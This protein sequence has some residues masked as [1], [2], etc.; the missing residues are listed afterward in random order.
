M[1]KIR[2]QQLVIGRKDLVVQQRILTIIYNIATAPGFIIKSMANYTRCIDICC[3][4]FMRSLW[5]YPIVVYGPLQ[6]LVKTQILNPHLAQTCRMMTVRN[7]N[8]IS[9]GNFLNKIKKS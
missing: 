7:T 9:K 3:I 6:T 4:S 1:V 8:Q 2:L 5:V